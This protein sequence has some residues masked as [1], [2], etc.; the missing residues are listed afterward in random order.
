MMLRRWFTTLACVI[1]GLPIAAAAPETSPR[2][3]SRPNPDAA[4]AATE[5]LAVARMRPHLRPASEQTI[6]AASRPEGLAFLSPDTSARPW[7]RPPSIESQAMAK[8]K[9][10]R[11]GAVCG[12][13]KIQGENVGYVPGRIKACGIKD[14][15]RVNTVA[16]VRLNPPALMNC[17]TAT[18]LRQWTELGL[19]PAFRQ[20]GPVVEVKVAAHY[21]CRTRNN[22]RGARISEHGKGNAIDL[23]AF[24]MMDG[25]VITV[26]KGWGQGTTRK[27]LRKAYKRACGVFGTTLGPGSDGYHRDHFHFDTASYRSGPY[28]R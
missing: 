27:P 21:A 25:E 26:L 5:L 18:A 6:I 1:W 22:K 11:K 7:P 15:V 28:C 16:G 12:D 23:S 10:R 8:R 24:T 9:L 3:Q 2:P 13:L 19:K 20:R 17:R 4:A 14:A